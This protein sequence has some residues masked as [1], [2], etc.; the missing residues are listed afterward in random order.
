MEPDPV[1]HTLFSML[2]IL[3]SCPWFGVLLLSSGLH[4]Q[5]KKVK[6]RKIREIKLVESKFT[7]YGTLSCTI[8]MMKIFPYILY[9]LEASKLD[10]LCQFSPTCFMI[11]ER[12][13]F[14]F[15]ILWIFFLL[16]F[17]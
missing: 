10:V 15:P 13:D 7:K 14:R 8:N 3:F 9:Y 4:C 17:F 1:P 11:P 5:N 2:N 6:E 16:C 12:A